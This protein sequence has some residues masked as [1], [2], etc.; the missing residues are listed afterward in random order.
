MRGLR[1]G[2]RGRAALALAGAVLAVAIVLAGTGIALADKWTDISDVTWQSQYGVTA[3][4]AATV[5]GGFQDGSFHP[6]EAV[7]RGQFPRSAEVQTVFV[8]MGGLAW[9]QIRI[10][11]RNANL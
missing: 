6:K 8:L 1:R 7:K 3:N 9:L 2:V 5:A 10:M 11:S 4:E